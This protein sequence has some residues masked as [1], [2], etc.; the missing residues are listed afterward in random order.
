M[1]VS[2]AVA[3]G[4]S[5]P[6]GRWQSL[7]RVE[8]PDFSISDSGLTQ[9]FSHQ[10]RGAAAK[11]RIPQRRPG[12]CQRASVLPEVQDPQ[13]RL[14]NHCKRPYFVQNRCELMDVS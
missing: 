8:E 7:K 3:A 10:E 13:R 11:P 4:P 14:G 12:C 9:E 6:S 5:I 2:S 1:Q